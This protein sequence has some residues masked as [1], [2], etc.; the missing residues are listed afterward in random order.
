MLCRL[1]AISVLLNL[2]CLNACADVLTAQFW[3]LPAGSAYGDTTVQGLKDA[4]VLNGAPFA[5]RTIRSLRTATWI[6]NPYNNYV[7][8]VQGYLVPPETGWYKIAVASDDQ[9]EFHLS[10]DHLPA[11]LELIGREPRHSNFPPFSPTRLDERS[12]IVWLVKGRQYWFEGYWIEFA[13]GDFLHV[14]WRGRD[15][16]I[17]EITEANLLAPRSGGSLSINMGPSNQTAQELDPKT[18]HPSAVFGGTPPFHCQWSRDGTE[19][20]G[21]HT[22][23]FN[24]DNARLTDAGI[25]SC[26]V[27]DATGAAVTGSLNLTVVPTTGSFGCTA[28][29]V[30]TD[31]I[32]L[33]CSRSLDPNT[34]LVPGNYTFTD[35]SV[36]VVRVT[37]GQAPNQVFIHA[38]GDISQSQTSELGGIGVHVH[39][40]TDA[41]AA[42][43]SVNKGPYHCPY[44]P[45][46]MLTWTGAD[47]ITGI[48]EAFFALIDSRPPDLTTFRPEMY[49]NET[50]PL[51]HNMR[52]FEAYFVP[53]SSG[54]HRFYIAS[55]DQSVVYLSTDADPANKVEIAKEPQWN[56]ARD[57]TGTDRRPGGE[58]ISE[59]IELTAGVK[60]YFRAYV[61]NGSGG[62]H[63]GLTVQGPG[64][65]VP[66]NFSLPSMAGGSWQPVDTAFHERLFLAQH[67]KMTFNQDGSW[68]VQAKAEGGG[69]AVVHY[70]FLIDGRFYDCNQSG[71]FDGLN[72][73]LGDAIGVRANAVDPASNSTFDSAWGVPVNTKVSAIEAGPAKKQTITSNSA[74]S[75]NTNFNPDDE[76]QFRKHGLGDSSTLGVGLNYADNRSLVISDAWFTKSTAGAGDLN[77]DGPTET[78]VSSEGRLEM[79][80]TIGGDGPLGGILGDGKLK[81]TLNTPSSVKVDGVSPHEAGQI[82]E[83]ART[84]QISITTADGQTEINW[85]DASL[86]RWTPGGSTQPPAFVLSEGGG[87]SPVFEVTSPPGVGLNL[88]HTNQLPGPWVPFTP[89]ALNLDSATGVQ[90][91]TFE[92]KD[93]SGFF[94]ASTDAVVPQDR[95]LF[96]ENRIITISQVDFTWQEPATDSDTGAVTINLGELNNLVGPGQGFL[97]IWGDANVPLSIF[98]VDTERSPAGETTT[99]FPLG[100]EPGVDVESIPLAIW[101]TPAP[102]AGPPGG[103]ALTWPVGDLSYNGQG[104]EEPAPPGLMPAPPTGV[105]TWWY[106]VGGEVLNFSQGPRRLVQAAFM[107]CGAAAMADSMNWLR[108][109]YDIELPHPHKPGLGDDGSLVGTLETYMGRT[110]TDRR[111]GEGTT[112]EQQIKGKLEY[113]ARHNLGEVI[114]VK[115]WTVIQPI[116]SDITAH[117]L[118]STFMGVPNVAAILEEVSR[119]EDVEITYVMPIPGMPG[120]FM[121][122]VVNVL[123]AG[124]WGGHFEGN[125]YVGGEPFVSFGTDIDQNSDTAGLTVINTSLGDPDGDGVLNLL[126]VP[127]TPAIVTIVSESPRH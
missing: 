68:N 87:G 40:V 19:I 36:N 82:L 102:P 119:G 70:T 7:A 109:T 59:P 122:H 6:G 25:Y 32:A 8:R 3:P 11:G 39:G 30:G 124:A 78:S 51:D 43:N 16:K 88:E 69:G 84:A 114:T 112:D 2:A 117:D 9:G 29:L 5:T 27:T 21:A 14:Q 100:T 22:L 92:D 75:S 41:S 33:T 86:I 113:L 71:W 60:Y 80:R 110:A 44:S 49:M 20:S 18:L 35:S 101:Y 99:F 121:G 125:S 17:T 89:T 105:E 4:G 85:D 34:A 57:W 38:D 123:G 1:V 10:N 62:H 76:E 73:V 103:L 126:R 108:E 118:T 50:P 24:I 91:F 47:H 120:Q 42:G 116:Q 67:I 54:P 115:H 107:Q 93:P 37:L 96:A 53:G 63:F 12:S 97:S 94:R 48:N 72:D 52:C 15:G 79:S 13:G 90:T 28:N 127:G 26:K 104:N 81:I 45:V 31:A 106:G 83:H 61:R 95:Q 46:R 77:L 56:A 111:Q 64:D 65:P 23:S 55:D 74:W 66:A 98:P 58:N